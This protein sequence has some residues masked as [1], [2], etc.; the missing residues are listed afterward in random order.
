MEDIK[1]NGGL[2]NIEK[3]KL[4]DKRAGRQ[5]RNKKKKTEMSKRKKKN[6]R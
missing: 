2:K 6:G 3:R 5:G 4:V 1:D